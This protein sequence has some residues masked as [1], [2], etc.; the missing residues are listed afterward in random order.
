[1]IFSICAGIRQI[2]MRRVCAVPILL[3]GLTSRRGEEQTLKGGGSRVVGIDGSFGTAAGGAGDAPDAEIENQ[4]IPG[5]RDSGGEAGRIR[6]TGRALP[7]SFC[8]EV[9]SKTRQ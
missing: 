9:S 7:V 8:Y 2:K 4:N 3:L 5:R 1:M 6:Q